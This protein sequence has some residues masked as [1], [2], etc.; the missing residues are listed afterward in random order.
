MQVSP[1][2]PWPETDTHPNPFM[3]DNVGGMRSGALKA[4]VGSIQFFFP[5][6]SAALRIR[7]IVLRGAKE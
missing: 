1:F 7:V 2:Q 4:I 5:G 3:E 6:F